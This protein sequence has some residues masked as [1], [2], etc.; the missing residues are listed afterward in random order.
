MAIHMSL[1][2]LH[3]LSKLNVRPKAPVARSKDARSVCMYYESS[4]PSKQSS[5]KNIR[6]HS[7]A[8]HSKV[9]LICSLLDFV[10]RRQKA[11][12]ISILATNWETKRTT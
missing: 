2:T 3:R 12:L 8:K 1:G 10:K 5:F 9:I 7:E 4:P 6:C 11:W